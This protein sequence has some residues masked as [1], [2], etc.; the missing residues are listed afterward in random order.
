M[1]SKSFTLPIAYQYFS[2]CRLCTL[3]T[4]LL[5]YDDAHGLA[6]SLAIAIDTVAI[7]NPR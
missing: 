7:I 1:S 2:K 3:Y 5:Y 4:Y 6:D